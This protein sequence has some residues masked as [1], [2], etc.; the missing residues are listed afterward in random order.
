MHALDPSSVPALMA[1]GQGYGVR[2]AIAAIAEHIELAAK[3]ADATPNIVNHARH[4]GMS[5][6]NTIARVNQLLALAEQ[7]RSAT[8]AAEAAKLVSQMASLAEQLVA[9]ADANGDGRVTF[10]EGE[11]GLQLVDEHVKLMLPRGS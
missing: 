9:G 6:R 1:P 4:V 7:V 10:E 11:G 3:E 5:A 8:S 2:K